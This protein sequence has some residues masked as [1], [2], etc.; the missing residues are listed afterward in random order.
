MLWGRQARLPWS[1]P[2]ISWVP[3]RLPPLVALLL[4]SSLRNVVNADLFYLLALQHA[5]REGALQ[6]DPSWGLT[7][8]CLFTLVCPTQAVGR[9][10]R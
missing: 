10:G 2:V 8:L 5:L 9:P 6:Q 7:V 4:C 1:G 3:K